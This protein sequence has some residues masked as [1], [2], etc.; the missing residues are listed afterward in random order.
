VKAPPL[1]AAGSISSTESPLS[2][3]SIRPTSGMST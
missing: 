2:K 1:A 3:T